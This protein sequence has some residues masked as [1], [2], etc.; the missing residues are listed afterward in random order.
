MS[1]DGALIQV[2]FHCLGGAGPKRHPRQ[3]CWP[4][5]LAGST[6]P[7]DAGAATRGNRRARMLKPLS[8]RVDATAQAL[9]FIELVEPEDDIADLFVVKSGLGLDVLE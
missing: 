2:T 1:A 8:R 3:R 7:A 9:D 4:P 6:C 5:E